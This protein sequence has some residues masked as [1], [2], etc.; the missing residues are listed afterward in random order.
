MYIYMADSCCYTAQTQSNYI[1][2]KMIIKKETRNK[3]LYP[4][5]QTSALWI[6]CYCIVLWSVIAAAIF[7]SL[8]PHGLQNTGLPCPSLSP[9]VCSNSCPL[10]QGCHPTISCSVTPFSSCPQPSWHQGLFQWVG[11]LYK[12]A[13]ILEFQLQ[14]QSFQWIFRV[15]FL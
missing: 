15:D 3:Y 7:N 8:W 2:I 5:K 6:Q 10:S 11:S 12:V 13:R 4:L 1:P 9:G 14:H